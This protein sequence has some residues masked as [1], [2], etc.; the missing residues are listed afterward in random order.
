LRVS[1]L[2][3]F[4]GLHRA[5]AVGALEVGEHL[6]DDW[7]ARRASGRIGRGRRRGVLLL[8]GRRAVRAPHELV[9]D[10]LARYATRQEPT[11]FL[12]TPV[13]D[14]RER[15]E[16]LRADQA[17]AIDEEVRRAPSLE[18]DARRFVVEQRRPVR[19]LVDGRLDFLRVEPELGRDLRKGARLE[20][21][22]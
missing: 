11:V 13:D 14:R 9:E 2:E 7:R 16:R 4:D 10:A 1:L 6:H 22:G 19:V 12:E 20:P 18:I 17:L 3:L 5:A 8:G 21:W 15:L